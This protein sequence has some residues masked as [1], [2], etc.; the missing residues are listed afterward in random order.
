[1]AWSAHLHTSKFGLEMLGIKRWGSCLTLIPEEILGYFNSWVY[2]CGS[3]LAWDVVKI[4]WEGAGEDLSEGKNWQKM[5]T[6]SVIPFLPQTREVSSLGVLICF[7]WSWLSK[8]DRSAWFSAELTLCTYRRC[9]M[10]EPSR[11]TRVNLRVLKPLKR[12]RKNNKNILA[13]TSEEKVYLKI[14]RNP[15]EA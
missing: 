14:H 11:S 5:L 15:R 3:F 13:N 12:D 6:F 9:L 7:F 1:M 2:I 8:I 10:C 4:L